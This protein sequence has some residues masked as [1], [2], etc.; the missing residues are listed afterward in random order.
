VDNGK[1]TLLELPVPSSVDD[2]NQYVSSRALDYMNKVSSPRQALEVFKAEFD[3]IWEMGGMWIAVWHPA[4]SGRPAPALAIRE[5]IEYMLAKG[6]VWFA[7]HEEIAAHAR[8]LMADGRWQP[9]VE[10]VPLYDRP[11]V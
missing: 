2:Y 6:G 8:S 7:K 3:A 11:V 5:L 10:R 1:G 4:V 9:R